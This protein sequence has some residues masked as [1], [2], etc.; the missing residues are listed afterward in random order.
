MET[1]R[2]RYLPASDKILQYCVSKV[3]GHYQNSTIGG[4]PRNR[5]LGTVEGYLINVL[6][7]SFTPEGRIRFQRIFRSPDE[8]N[9]VKD[10]GSLQLVESRTE[11]QFS[12]PEK[13]FYLPIGSTYLGIHLEPSNNNPPT[14]AS[15][16]RELCS[17][18][19]YLK[20]YG[21]KFPFDFVIAITHAKLAH[22]ASRYGFTISGTPLPDQIQEEF[23]MR[24]KRKYKKH[25]VDLQNVLLSFQSFKS[26][27]DRFAA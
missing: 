10:F 15:I 22:V 21:E 19:K 3:N 13:R 23:R 14:L 11:F 12:D 8:Y 18:G 1:L 4:Q 2:G 6:V 25:K 24:F 26:L 5:F 16:N 27:T 20:N 9:S 7:H 17:V